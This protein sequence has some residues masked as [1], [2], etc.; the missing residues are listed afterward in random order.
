MSGTSMDGIDAAVITT[1]GIRVA[2]FGPAMTVPYDPGFRRRLKAALAGGGDDELERDLT[3]AHGA[4]VKKLLNENG[5]AAAEIAVIGFHGQTVFH[6]PANGI[7]RQLGDG[8]LLAAETRIPVVNDFRSADMAAGGEGAPMAPLY[9]AALAALSS[10][11][12]GLERPLCV[13]NIGGVAN[14]TWLGEADGD[15][16]AFD[17]GPGNALIDDWTA[18]TIGRAMDE[19]GRLARGGQADGALVAE[20]MSHSYFARTPPKSLD[21]DTFAAALRRLE[22]ASLSP[23]DGA[24]TLT[25]FTVRA[26]VKA[27]EYFPLKAKCWIVTGGGR[28]NGWMMEKLAAALGGPVV[29]AEDVGWRGDFLEA[30][31]FAFLAVRSLAGLPLSLPATTGADEPTTGGVLY[32]P[33]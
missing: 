30:E 27:A 31:A 15:I 6:D 23:A 8:A 19:G 12:G 5:I 16:A 11:A 7:T 33:D 2:E 1:D 32:R 20:F 17:C 10:L 13:L 29:A 3:I 14:A 21:R 24:A 22:E 28:L 18:R 25:A 4:A 9:H 26:V